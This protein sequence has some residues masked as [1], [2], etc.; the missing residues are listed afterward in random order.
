MQGENKEKECKTLKVTWEVGNK[1]L[2]KKIAD[3]FGTYSQEKYYIVN[4]H[5]HKPAG[6]RIRCIQIGT[7][8]SKCLSLLII[9]LPISIAK[10][11]FHSSFVWKPV[12]SLRDQFPESLASWLEKKD[13]CK[14]MWSASLKNILLKR[15]FCVSIESVYDLQTEIVPQCFGFDP[16]LSLKNVAQKLGIQHELINI[17]HKRWG[18]PILLPCYEW[19]M[20][21]NFLLTWKVMEAVCS[22]NT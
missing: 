10:A 6:Q 5:F 12:K 20:R 21:N 8:N 4:I 13:A 9:I 17:S 3:W 16:N 1:D 19:Y 14:Y 7:S 11:T 15:Q 18:D 2:D 22:T